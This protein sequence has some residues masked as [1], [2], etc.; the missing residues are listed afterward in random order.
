MSSIDSIRILL[1]Y[2]Y[3]TG[4]GSQLIIHCFGRFS[5]LLLFSL[6]AFFFFFT[7][8]FFRSRRDLR[9]SVLKFACFHSLSATL[10]PPAS[11]PIF[12]TFPFSPSTRSNPALLHL[13]PSL[14]TPVSLHRDRHDL[15]LLL[16]LLPW[17][18]CFYAP[19]L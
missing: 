17:I 7:F 19:R 14:F 15:H 10:S 16:C 8:L 12:F 11:A 2:H 18:C 13:F 6:Y 5:L 3:E 4:K 9:T 1:V